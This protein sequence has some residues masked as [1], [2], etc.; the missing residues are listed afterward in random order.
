[1]VDTDENAAKRQAARSRAAAAADRRLQALEMRKMG[2]TYDAI[3]KQLEIT[4]SAAHKAVRKALEQVQRLSDETAE[5]L[6]A[7]ELERLNRM[8]TGLWQKATSG[9]AQAVDKVLK[10]MER[11]SKLLGLDAP[12][13]IAKTDTAG[14]DIPERTPAD[15]SN[16]ELDA[17]ILE[18]TQ[19]TGNDGSQ[20]IH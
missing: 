1:M 15:M 14:Q 16:D 6:R 19:K 13:K 12:T 7:I 10:I 3:A 2:M 18:L 4:P 8:Q 17:R 11:R 20:G 9:S 5:E